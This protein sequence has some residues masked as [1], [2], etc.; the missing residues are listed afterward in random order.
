MIKQLRKLSLDKLLALLCLFGFICCPS[1]LA[2]NALWRSYY[3]AAQRAYQEGN[4]TESQDL[5]LTALNSAS[6][7]DETLSTY[8]YLAHSDVKCGNFT[9]AEKYYRMLLEDLGTKTWAVVRP[10]DGTPD[11]DENASKVEQ[12]VDGNSFYSVLQKKPPQLLSVRLAKPIA[13]VDVLSDYGTFLQLTKRY[14]EAEAAYTRALWLSDCRPDQAANYE[15]KIL[16][17]LSVL[18]HLQ[19]KTAQEDAVNRQL[20]TARNAAVPDFDHILSE[21]IKGLDRFGH[22][23]RAQA[24]RLNNLALFCATHGDYAK[25]EALFN[26]ALSCIGEQSGRHKKDRALI[27]SN[28]SDLLMAMGRVSDAAAINKGATP[29]TMAPD[30]K[31][32]AQDDQAGSTRVS[33]F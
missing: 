23:P 13:I 31:Q 14:P 10:P 1:S 28:Y 18:Y 16:Q 12:A 15:L 27:L 24:I 2:Q 25:A 7:S 20:L 17:K 32:S 6:T 33:R 4:Y 21:T 19:S 30:T 3:G 5:L 29:L 22:N 8:F 11:W 9:D 26:R